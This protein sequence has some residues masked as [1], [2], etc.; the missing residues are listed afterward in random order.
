MKKIIL[1][2]ILLVVA[3]SSFCQVNFENVSFDGALQKSKQTG[4]LV[5]LQFESANCEQCNEVADKAFEDQIR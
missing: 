1:L 3:F 4:K 2:S 5:F